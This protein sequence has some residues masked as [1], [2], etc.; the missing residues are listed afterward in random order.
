MIKCNFIVI[1]CFT[2]QEL[3]VSSERYLEVTHEGNTY[4]LLEIPSENHTL[5]VKELEHMKRF[6]LDHLGED[7]SLLVLFFEIAYFGA[8]LSSRLQP[9]GSKCLT[10]VINLCHKTKNTL[11]TFVENSDAAVKKL[12]VA[13]QRLKENKEGIALD[14]FTELPEMYNKM[15][16]EL[17]SLLEKCR[18]QSEIIRDVGDEVLCKFKNTNEGEVKE[19]PDGSQQIM[20]QIAPSKMDTGSDY[21]QQIWVNESIIHKIL[22]LKARDL[23]KKDEA[24]IQE[25]TTQIIDVAIYLLDNIK[26]RMISVESHW[27]EI[28]ELFKPMGDNGMNGKT[29]KECKEFWQTDTFKKDNL[30]FYVKWIA[31]KKIFVK[32]KEHVNSKIKELEGYI[33]VTFSEDKAI[34][35]IQASAKKFYEGLHKLSYDIN[36]K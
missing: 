35:Y 18:E 15:K 24:S 8:K 19:L 22:F 36:N 14:R 1:K 6:Q 11:N 3:Q 12:N 30:N 32:A 28:E 26:L 23:C 31:L 4:N 13:Y 9:Y 7:F 34:E 10:I 25:T 33:Q 16:T 21:L 27:I 29:L 2:F 20:K 5:V 17:Q